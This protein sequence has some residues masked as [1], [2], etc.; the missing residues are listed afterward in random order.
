MLVCSVKPFKGSTWIQVRAAFEAVSVPCAAANREQHGYTHC[1]LSSVQSIH[2]ASLSLLIH[3]YWLPQ[4]FILSGVPEWVLSAAPTVPS[5]SEGYAGPRHGCLPE[6]SPAWT[7]NCLFAVGSSTSK[8]EFDCSRMSKVGW[9]IGDIFLLLQGMLPIWQVNLAGDT[10]S[11]HWGWCCLHSMSRLC[12]TSLLLA[13]SCKTNTA[14][15]AWAWTCLQW[16][17]GFPRPVEM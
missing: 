9:S 10:V 2:S 6:K 8:R 11:S 12:Q 14:M 16:E 1:A 5:V 15:V 13:V 4:P 17:A 7:A 3:W